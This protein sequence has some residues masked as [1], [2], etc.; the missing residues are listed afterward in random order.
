MIAF[1]RGVLE[2]KDSET[3]IID[4]NGVGYEVLI[5]ESTYARLP[6]VGTPDTKLYT[7]YYS[8]ND[9]VRLYG[10]IS[11]DDRKV[12]E[13][14]MGVKGVGPSYALNIVSK[15]SPSQFRAA[16]LEENV[17]TFNNIPRISKDT[18]QLIIMSLKKKITKID[19]SEQ[20]ISGDDLRQII[21]EAVEALVNL[22]ASRDAADEAVS[23]ARKVLGETSTREDLIRLGLR[24]V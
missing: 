18:A 10:F 2:Y 17:N 5:P 1:V 23:K 24:Y 6:D 3:A 15:L 14:S 4:V 21:D 19:F 20:A 13:A 12:F 9:E 22:G 8:W 11:P 16:I 7:Y